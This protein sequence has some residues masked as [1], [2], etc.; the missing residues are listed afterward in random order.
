MEF[1]NAWGI[2]CNVI[3]DGGRKRRVTLHY[4]PSDMVE[5]RKVQVVFLLFSGKFL[6]H[7]PR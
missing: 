2:F 1:S 5:E 3:Y 4:S 6:R 7:L